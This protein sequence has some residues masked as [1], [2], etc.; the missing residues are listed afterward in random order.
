MFSILKIFS[1]KNLHKSSKLTSCKIIHLTDN[2]CKYQTY[3]LPQN[4]VTVS[5][6]TNSYVALKLIHNKISCF[7]VKLNWTRELFFVFSHQG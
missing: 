3:F 7:K 5:N 2:Y 1:E 6:N 4:W